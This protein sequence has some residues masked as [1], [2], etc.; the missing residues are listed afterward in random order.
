[1]GS[2]VPQQFYCTGWEEASYLVYKDI[3]RDV[4]FGGLRPP[5]PPA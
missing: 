4:P 2:Y 3:N 5:P 1:M